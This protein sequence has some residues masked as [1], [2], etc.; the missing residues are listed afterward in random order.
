MASLLPSVWNLPEIFRQ[1]LG[2]QVGR[3]RAMVHEGHML[4]VMHEVPEPGV[5]ERV[6]LF[7]WRDPS[8]EWKTSAQGNGKTALRELVR[9]YAAR[10][11]ALEADYAVADTAKELFPVLR[12]AT[13]IVRSAK[14][15]LQVLQAAREACG[16]DKDII[17]LRDVAGEV[18]RA[19]D[20]LAEEARNALE[21]DIA[22]AAQEQAK[23]NRQLAVTGQRL[24]MLAAVFL[25]MTAVASVFGMNL[26]SGLE[27]AATPVLFWVT[28]GVGIAVGLLVR[29]MLAPPTLDPDPG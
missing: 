7:F 5:P 17:D 13:P 28:L 12:A 23:L 22:E 8:G 27:K 24:N 6:G 11:D 21:F 19:A 20:L 2:H 10:V 1:R 29:R 14:H 18:E 25:P 26:E 4:L 16:Q 3:Q 15:V 9:R